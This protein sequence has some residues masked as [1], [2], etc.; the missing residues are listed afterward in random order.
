MEQVEGFRVIRI[1]VVT[2][3]KNKNEKSQKIKELWGQFFEDR[4]EQ[5]PNRKAKKY[6]LSTQIMNLITKGN[7]LQ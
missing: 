5:I 3:N 2:T 6:T 7:T 1:S 4:L